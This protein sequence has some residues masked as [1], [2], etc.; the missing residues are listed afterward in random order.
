[1]KNI[2][3]KTWSTKDTVYSNQGR[4][5][6]KLTAKITSSDDMQPKYGVAKTS[7]AAKEKLTILF[8]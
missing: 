3:T 6:S 2:S 5:N 7:Y 8:N 4:H 1:M